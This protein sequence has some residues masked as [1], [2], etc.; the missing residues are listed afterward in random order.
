MN[1]HRLFTGDLEKMALCLNTY[2]KQKKIMAPGLYFLVHV[3]AVF[4]LLS[5]QYETGFLPFSPVLVIFL[6]LYIIVYDF[7]VY[8]F[9][10]MIRDWIYI[11]SQSKFSNM[12]V[13]FLF[14]R[15][16]VYDLTNFLT[17]FKVMIHDTQSF[18]L[19][20]DGSLSVVPYLCL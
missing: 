17:H 18:P 2:R 20:H 16:F 19:Q 3:F 7:K 8:C 12:I 10:V 4:V 5:F 15:I 11:S 14:F 9:K 13:V 1:L 6:F